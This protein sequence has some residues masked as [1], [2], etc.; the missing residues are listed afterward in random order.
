MPI[1]RLPDMNADPAKYLNNELAAIRNGIQQLASEREN[2]KTRN[3]Q[4]SC[5]DVTHGM[6]TLRDGRRLNDEMYFTSLL[7]Q[8]YKAETAQ[9]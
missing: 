6:A 1:T 7:S 8:A 2:Y 3:H 4:H 9:S 5:H